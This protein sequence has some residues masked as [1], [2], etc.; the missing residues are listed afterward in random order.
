MAM[1]AEKAGCEIHF[2]GER[3]LVNG[4]FLDLRESGRILDFLRKIDFAHAKFRNLVLLPETKV[5]VIIE[6]GFAE[7]GWPDAILVARTPDQK[8]LVF[9]V[10]A[11]AG[12]YED[13]AQDYTQREAGF[14]STIN[15]QFSLRYRL[16]CALRVFGDSQRRLE[17]PKNLATAYDELN[18]RRLSKLDNL[19]NIVRPHLTRAS[20]YFFVALT[21]DKANVWPVIETENPKLLPFL[22]D[23]LVPKATAW[24]LKHNTWSRNRVDF[25]CIGF[26]DIEPLLEDGRYFPCARQFLETKRSMVKRREAFLEA[27]RS[28]VKRREVGGRK[29][30]NIHT[31]RWKSFSESTIRLR[32]ALRRVIKQST[33]FRDGQLSYAKGKGSDSVID[34]QNQ[35]VLK[36][37][38]PVWPYDK[39]FDILFGVSVDTPGFPEDLRSRSEGF[40]G[41]KNRGFEIVGITERDFTADALAELVRDTLAN[42]IDPTDYPPRKQSAGPKS[43]QKPAA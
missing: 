21:D 15:G 13:E 31:K 19:R 17:E 33:P 2:Y 3:G 24:T 11:K 38:T 32:D 26:G 14:N 27:K 41:I 8:R 25:G 6:A 23:E 5:V 28:R 18:P 1:V 42:I 22:A 37:I 34:L 7:F 20:N 12:L 16:A 4:L 40:V 10:E 30:V 9:F 39:K 29:Y 36:L 43:S 35:R